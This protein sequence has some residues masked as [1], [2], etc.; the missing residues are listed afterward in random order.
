MQLWLE[1]KSI[2]VACMQ[3]HS[4]ELQDPIRGEVA[5]TRGGLVTQVKEPKHLSFRSLADVRIGCLPHERNKHCSITQYTLQT[6]VSHS[7]V[8]ILNQL[9]CPSHRIKGLQLVQLIKHVQLQFAVQALADPGE[10]LLSDFAKLDRSAQLH[11][12]FQALDAFQVC[13]HLRGV[14]FPRVADSSMHIGPDVLLELLWYVHCHTRICVLPL[15]R[16]S[17]GGCPHLHVR[18]MLQQFLQQRAS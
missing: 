17:M 2:R 13:N 18:Q 5:Y 12:G 15:F 16:L 3:A 11:L 9:H 8:R 10:F 4:F 6:I 1:V 14:H 7:S